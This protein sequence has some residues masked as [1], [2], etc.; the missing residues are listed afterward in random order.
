MSQ[1]DSLSLISAYSVLSSL[2]ESGVKD[3]GI[4]WP[5]DVY[6]GGRKICG[7]LLEGVSREEMECLIIGIGINVNQTVFEGDYLREPTSLAL[8]TGKEAD[9]EDFRKNV[10]SKLLNNLQLLK[11]G[12]DFSEEIRKYDWLAGKEGLAE[13][14]GKT[15][16]IKIEGIERDGSL[17][18]IYHDRERKLRSGEIS[19]HTGGEET[20]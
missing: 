13:I 6:A 9:R 1:Y 15:E 12:H 17:K 10:Y 14:E 19:F 2:K 3:V 4:K 11:K 18:I 5:N 16:K 7:I 8:E 20:L